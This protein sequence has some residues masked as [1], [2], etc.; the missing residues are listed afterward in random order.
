MSKPLF[1]PPVVKNGSTVPTAIIK[2]KTMSLRKQLRWFSHAKSAR[3][4]SGKTS[5][6]TKKQTSI[7]H[8]VTTSMS[9]MLSPKRTDDLLS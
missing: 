7:V 3:R 8:F 4:Y 5:S 6:N 9:L 1:V 2:W